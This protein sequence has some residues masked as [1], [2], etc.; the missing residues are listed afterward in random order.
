MLSQ[1]SAIRIRVLYG[2]PRLTHEW[3]SASLKRVGNGARLDKQFEPEERT[4]G[5]AK[6]A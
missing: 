4:G 6:T 2:R 3:P 5:G 1:P